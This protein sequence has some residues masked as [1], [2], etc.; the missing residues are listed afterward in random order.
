VLGEYSFLKKNEKEKKECK[1]LK[2]VGASTKCIKL[3]LCRDTFLLPARLVRF[4]HN[5]PP[6]VILQMQQK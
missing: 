6:A 5:Y 2:I 3:G 1:T 4:A